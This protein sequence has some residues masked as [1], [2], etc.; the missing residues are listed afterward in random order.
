MK[1]R[2]ATWA[3]LLL[4]FSILGAWG[5][6]PQSGDHQDAQQSQTAPKIVVNPPSELVIRAVTADELREKM[7]YEL[8]AWRISAVTTMSAALAIDPIQY[9]NAPA[10]WTHDEAGDHMDRYYELKKQLESLEAEDHV[11]AQGRSPDEKAGSD[12][13]KP[14]IVNG[15]AEKASETRPSVTVTGS[16]Q[17]TDKQHATE[18]QN[19]DGGHV[20][21]GVMLEGEARGLPPIDPMRVKYDRSLNALILGDHIYLSKSAPRIFATLCRAIAA[22]DHELVGVSL[23]APTYTV[24]GRGSDIYRN[25]DLGRDLALSD[26]FL[27]DIVFL[28][29]HWETGY[30]HPSDFEPKRAIA[31]NADLIVRWSFRDYDFQVSNNGEIQL[32]HANV[33]ARIM[34]V[35]FDKEGQFLPDDALLANGFLPPPEYVSNADNVARHFSDFYIHEPLLA[36]VLLEYGPDAAIIRSMKKAGVNLEKLANDIADDRS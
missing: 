28:E 20:G 12:H 31:T 13:G 16:Y 32:S 3:L 29:G 8:A 24:F 26:G 19:N 2:Y 10:D 15:Q 18:I 14:E 35:K 4:G 34:P 1:S 30:R 9:N 11:A 23:T 17:N 36:R 5:Q 6:K 25:T 33:E 27:R 21:G 22:D 7:D